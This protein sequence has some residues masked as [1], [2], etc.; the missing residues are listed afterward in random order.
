MYRKTA[1]EEEWFQEEGYI[2]KNRVKDGFG[3]TVLM[4]GQPSM[5]RI[6]KFCR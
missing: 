1:E 6:K 5:N 4:K 3:G 2:R